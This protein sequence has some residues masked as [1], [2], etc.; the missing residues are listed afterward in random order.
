MYLGWFLVL[1]VPIVLLYI[2]TI[3]KCGQCEDGAG[4]TLLEYLK[5]EKSTSYRAALAFMVWLL[6]FSIRFAWPWDALAALGMMLMFET[7]L[8]ASCGSRK[9][10]TIVLL[11]FSFACIA[12]AFSSG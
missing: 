12:L 5:A 4:Y 11:V 10:I 7:I 6:A 3:P 1:A 2:F 9:F 8:F